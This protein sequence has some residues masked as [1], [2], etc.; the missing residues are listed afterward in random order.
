MCQGSARVVQ[1]G[2]SHVSAAH[3]GVQM[4]AQACIWSTQGC[5][6]ARTTCRSWCPGH[7][8]VILALRSM[9]VHVPACSQRVCTATCPSA[10]VPGTLS[11]PLPSAHILYDLALAMEVIV[12]VSLQ[13][14]AAEG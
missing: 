7:A 14:S 6:W 12:M 10:K 3:L 4:A 13:L 5:W 1:A 8:H 11:W 9:G 2:M